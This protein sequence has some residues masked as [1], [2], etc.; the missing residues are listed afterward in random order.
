MTFVFFLAYLVMGGGGGGKV[1]CGSRGTR[2]PSG[3]TLAEHLF[4]ID[5]MKKIAAAQAIKF[6]P[7]FQNL[8][9]LR[10]L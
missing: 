6:G 4:K 3:P 9:S 5:F 7:L 1:C 8:D 10:K 2:P